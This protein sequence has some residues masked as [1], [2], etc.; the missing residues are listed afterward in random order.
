MSN[1]TAADVETIREGAMV[2]CGYMRGQLADRLRE[3]AEKIEEG[4]E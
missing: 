3:V 1:L 4:L 2:L